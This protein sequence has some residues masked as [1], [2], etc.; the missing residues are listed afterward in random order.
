MTMGKCGKFFSGC[1]ECE[2]CAIL[3]EVSFDKLDTSSVTD[4]SEMFRDVILQVPPFD[5][6]DDSLGEEDMG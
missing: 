4:M 3:T 2:K 6:G 5:V 1:S